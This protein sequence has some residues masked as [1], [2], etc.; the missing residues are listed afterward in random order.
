[1]KAIVSTTPGGPDTLT[2]EDI[3]EPTP[4]PDE[5]RINVKACGVNYPDTLM[6]EDKYQWYRQATVVRLPL[7]ALARD[8]VARM[9]ERAPPPPPPLTRCL[10]NTWCAVCKGS[11]SN[12]KS[13]CHWCGYIP[14]P[15]AH[16]RTHYEF[17]CLP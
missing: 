17:V 3:D 9:I 7:P 12:F 6:I 10:T 5:V 4:A 16:T 11:R 8:V 15:P 13:P 2:L 14:V 1:M